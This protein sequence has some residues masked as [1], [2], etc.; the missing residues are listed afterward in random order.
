MMSPSEGLGGARV[1]PA[2]ER[3]RAIANFT[4]D[5]P[6]SVKMNLLEKFLAARRR[7]QHERCVRYPERVRE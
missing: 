2:G 6:L 5:M 4:S 7:N 1:S 3:V